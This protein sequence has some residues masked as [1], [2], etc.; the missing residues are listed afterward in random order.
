MSRNLTII[1]IIFSIF[2]ALAI[3][4]GLAW[5]NTLYVRAH[6]VEKQFIVPWLAARTYLQ[7]GI[8]PYDDQTTQ[9][10]QIVYYGRLIKENE[11]PLRLSTP[12]PAELLYFPFALVTDYAFARGL[13]MTLGE[14]ALAGA[15]F[16]CLTLTGWK[17]RRF[18]LPI[19]LL[20]SILWVYAMMPLTSGSPAPFVALGLLGALAAMRAEKDELAGALLALSLLEPG[21]AAVF[22]LFVLWWTVAFRRGKV[23]WGFLMAAGFFTTV[24]FLLI[25]SWF[26][27]FLRGVVSHSHYNPGLTVA[28][29][30][31]DWWPALGLKLSL[32]ITAG[33]GAML[34]LEFRS[35]RGKDFRHSLWVASLTLA[36]APLT[37]LPVSLDAHLLLLLPLL[38]LLAVV[39]ERWSGTR[40]VFVS[41][42]ILA[43]V[44]SLLWLMSGSIHGL[45]FILPFILLV[46]LYWVRWWAVHPPRT[47]VDTLPK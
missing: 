18:L 20:F 35:L 15:A 29:L 14:I 3:L 31:A 40:A 32:A 27:P 33:L 11:D 34:F 30:L 42:G 39:P 10:A 2:L 6:P 21:I 26:M 9:R 45:F 44:F 8:S 41:G 16:L 24:S 47:W 5:G 22:L 13:W 37:G 12:L 1:G 25:P 23:W 46:S 43:G 17:P 38:L 36:A 28:A 4:G 19:V 7:Y